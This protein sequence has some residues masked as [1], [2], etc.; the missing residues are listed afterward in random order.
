MALFRLEM[1]ISLENLIQNY[2][3]TQDWQK[4]HRISISILV[5]ED[6]RTRT[7]RIVGAH[8]TCSPITRVES[9]VGIPQALTLP[10]PLGPHYLTLYNITFP[11]SVNCISICSNKRPGSHNN[12]SSLTAPPTSCNHLPVSIHAICWPSSIW[13][14]PLSLLPLLEFSPS[15]PSPG[16]PRSLP[17]K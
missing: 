12:D 10:M 16:P 3:S 6:L 4:T 11:I 13:P 1:I 15:Y 14:S 8:W 9:P 7:G 2:L 5:N 17:P